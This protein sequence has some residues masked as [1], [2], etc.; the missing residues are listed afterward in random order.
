[1][2]FSFE[3]SEILKIVEAAGQMLGRFATDPDYR[4]PRAKEDGSP[5][6]RADIE[7]SEFLVR[8][9]EVFG[10]PVISEEGSKP[11]EAPDSYFLV[12]PLDGTQGF[13]R[14]ESDFAVLV[15]FVEK[16]LPVL[17]FLYSPTEGD[18]YWAQAGAG[19]YLN[20]QSIENSGPVGPSLRAF[21]SGFHSHDDAQFLLKAL[22]IGSI[23][24][25]S[26]ALKFC[27]IA[28][29][30]A[31]FFPRYGPTGEWDT[32]AAQ[33]LLAEAGCDFLDLQTMKTLRYGKPKWLNRGFVVCHRSLT[34]QVQELF[35]NN[36]IRKSQ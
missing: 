13:T 21:S 28:R 17:G 30:R 19:A 6:T 35:V 32:A 23:M 18:L 27:D 33:V 25:R 24:R 29:G 36:P 16:T 8:E 11:L 15:G 3:V 9:L 12:D 5:V 26:S 20:G 22:N 2:S 7:V 10:Y 14:G 34:K 1:M 31:D 4:A